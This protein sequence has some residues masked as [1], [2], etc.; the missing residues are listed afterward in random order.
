[1]D[2]TRGGRETGFL[3]LTTS[4]S[5]ESAGDLGLDDAKGSFCRSERVEEG[6]VVGEDV[7]YMQAQPAN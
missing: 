4:H 3:A 6:D 1:M 2:T 7:L 5:A